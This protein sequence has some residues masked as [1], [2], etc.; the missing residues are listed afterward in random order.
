MINKVKE[1]N[2][3][4]NQKLPKKDG[5]GG[6][7]DDVATLKDLKNLEE[8][9][10]LRFES[11]DLKFEASKDNINMKFDSIDLK[12][13]AQE[14][15]IKNMFLEEREAQRKYKV[16]SIKWTVGTGIAVT[17]LVFTMIKFFL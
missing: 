6:G 13:D 7:M 4:R 9:I 10:N 12:F 11:V 5:G 1:L 16:E 17:G 14:K 15:H 2:E 8:K 3:Y